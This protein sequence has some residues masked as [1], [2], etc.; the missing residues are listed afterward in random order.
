VIHAILVDDSEEDLKHAGRLT[1]ERF[2]CGGIQPPDRVEDLAAIVADRHAEGTCNV[3]LLDYRL[4][5]EVAAADGA[6]R[7]Y[8]G[9]TAAAAIRESAPNIPIVLVTTEPKLRGNLSSRPKV[10]A[11][12]DHTI[13]KSRLANRQERPS[14]VAELIS[15]AEGFRTIASASGSGWKRL[16]AIAGL[17]SEDRL[18]SL[19][20]AHPPDDPSSVA[21]WLLTEALRY[22]GPLVDSRSAAALLGLSE[23]AFERSE[24]QAAIS[25]AAYCGAFAGSHRRWWA[26]AL[27]RWVSRLQ[28]QHAQTGD[29]DRRS[30]IATHLGLTRNQLRAAACVWCGSEDAVRACAICRSPVDPQHCIPAAVDERPRWADDAYVCFTCVERGRD[31]QAVYAASAM[32]IVDA[33]RS[34]TLRPDGQADG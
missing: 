24:V 6:R 19:G 25:S 33:I 21:S 7:N 1:T 5:A 16:A 20:E 31:H 9:G 23:K 3:V 13:L 14:I 4:D 30:A 17:E 15:L 10:E 32:A 34:G 29:S 26:E 18:L 28:R 8:R 27:H 22:P 2:S 12:F 11:L